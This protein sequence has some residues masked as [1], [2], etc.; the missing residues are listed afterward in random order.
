MAKVTT[1]YSGYQSDMFDNIDDLDLDL[2]VIDG[3][4]DCEAPSFGLSALAL[5]LFGLPG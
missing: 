4:F 3:T 5:L 1:N 2:E